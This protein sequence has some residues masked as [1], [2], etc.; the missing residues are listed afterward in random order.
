MKSQH[1][2]SSVHDLAI[3]TRS[4]QTS[5]KEKDFITTSQTVVSQNSAEFFH[6]DWIDRAAVQ[7]ILADLV[8]TIAHHTQ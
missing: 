5:H 3:S 2:L 6:T 1:L 7:T 4:A 8:S